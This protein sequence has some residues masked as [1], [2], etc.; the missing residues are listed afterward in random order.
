MKN[1]Y[2][3]LVTRQHKDL[4]LPKQINCTHKP[5]TV[6]HFYLGKKEFIIEQVGKRKIKMLVL[7]HV[8]YVYS[9]YTSESAM[10]I[11]NVIEW[12]LKEGE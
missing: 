5:L 2:Q 12:Y 11:K 3:F 9:N 10:Q 1:L 7:D 8:Y 6:L 4:T